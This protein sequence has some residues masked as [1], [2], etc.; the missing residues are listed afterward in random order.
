[1][2]PRGENC[3]AYRSSW[4]QLKWGRRR[5][6]RGYQ[7]RRIT[8]AATLSSTHLSKA[9]SPSFLGLIRWWAVKTKAKTRR[10]PATTM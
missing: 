5:Q 9:M 7:C 1:M 4:F 8:H 6:T 10:I 3:A 2:R